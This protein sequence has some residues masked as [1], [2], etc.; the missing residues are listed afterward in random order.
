MANIT[1]NFED[2]AVLASSLSSAS[3]GMQR[4]LDQLESNLDPLRTQFT[5]EAADAYQ[6]AKA[7][8]ASQMTQMTAFLGSISNAAASAGKAYTA[9][10]RDIAKSF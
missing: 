1:V 2:I 7:K 8:W 4:T 10:E 3:E 6:L 5:G 9:T